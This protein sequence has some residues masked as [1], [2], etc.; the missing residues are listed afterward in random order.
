MKELMIFRDQVFRFVEQDWYDAIKR[1]ASV[2]TPRWR[3]QGASQKRGENDGI[4]QRKRSQAQTAQKGVSRQIVESDSGST[5][6]MKQYSDSERM[7]LPA[8]AFVAGTS[9]IV[10]ATQVG[11]IHLQFLY[12]FNEALQLQSVMVLV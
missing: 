3:D 1:T 6:S 11:M 9:G 4:L 7:T 8:L 10:A 5:K 2:W 12:L